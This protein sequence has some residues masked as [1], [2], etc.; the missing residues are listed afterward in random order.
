M[1]AITPRTA[2][3]VIFL[4]VA[5]K[6][7]EDGVRKRIILAFAGLALLAGCGNQGDK[8]P[9]IPTEPK[10]KGAPYRLALDTKPA[11][12]NPAVITIPPVK[13]TA[14]PEAL[15]TRVLLAMRFTA[16]AAAGQEPV[17]H[18]MIGSPVDIKGEDGTLPAD[19]MTRASK[20]LSEYLDSYCLQG[21]VNLSLALARSS[22]NPQAS[23]AEVDAK[24]L[25][26]WMPTEVL[27][28]NPHQ[29]KCKP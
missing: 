10:W 28:K 2:T 13:Y 18:R 9:G 1:S 15:E 26:D 17:E 7:E 14:N 8:A 29:P 25:S 22:L 12:P 3:Q 11:K 5:Q 6:F 21:K 16:P 24:R 4:R 23:D 20:G 19:Y 27:Y